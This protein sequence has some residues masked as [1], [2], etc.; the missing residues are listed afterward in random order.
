MITTGDTVGAIF[1]TK[2][3]SVFYDVDECFRYCDHKNRA[4]DYA[5]RTLTGVLTHLEQLYGH[6][7]ILTTSD[8]PDAKMWHVGRV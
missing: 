3:S 4:A 2:P 1:E 5:G 8:M 7:L 6:V